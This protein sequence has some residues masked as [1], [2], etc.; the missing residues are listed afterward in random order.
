MFLRVYKESV[1]VLCLNFFCLS[2]CGDKPSVVVVMDMICE[3]E[4]TITCESEGE[5]ID[6]EKCVTFYNMVTI[7][8]STVNLTAQKS[9]VKKHFIVACDVSDSMNNRV[10]RG[11][12]YT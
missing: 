2:V 9:A 3:E 10:E 5:S 1:K 12:S 6:H 4:V 7:D 11:Q 8:A